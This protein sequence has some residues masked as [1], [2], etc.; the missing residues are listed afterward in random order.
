MN[1]PEDSPQRSNR[2]APDSRPLVSTQAA[3]ESF[4]DG[5]SN[6]E[7]V[8]RRVAGLIGQLWRNGRLDRATL[9]S[10]LRA[11]R[12]RGGQDNDQD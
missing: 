6:L 9:L 2:E 12:N 3:L 5:L 1:P 8:D 11:S 4:M 7:G 10:A